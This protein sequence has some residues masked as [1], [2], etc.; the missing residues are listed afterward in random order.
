VSD[1]KVSFTV[2]LSRD[3]RGSAPTRLR[4]GLTLSEWQPCL[5]G[6]AASRGGSWLTGAS[7]AMNAAPGISI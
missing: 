1:V 6:G 7:S 2:K 3:G 4:P 5:H